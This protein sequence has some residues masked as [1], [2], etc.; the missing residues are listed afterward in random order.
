MSYIIV[1]LRANIHLIYD[2][3][4]N[5]FM[6]ELCMCTIRFILCFSFV[7]FYYSHVFDSHLFIYL[8]FC[9]VRTMSNLITFELYFSFYFRTQ[10]VFVFIFIQFVDVWM[11]LDRRRSNFRICVALFFSSFS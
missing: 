9:S 10:T 5:I 4:E 2:T 1:R 3:G 6:C 7:F 11:T 8:F